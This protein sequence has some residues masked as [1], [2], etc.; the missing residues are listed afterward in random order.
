MSDV[1]IDKS[2]VNKEATRLSAESSSVN[3]EVS[4]SNAALSVCIAGLHSL[5]S[6]INDYIK[7]FDSGNKKIEQAISEINNQIQIKMNA[8][9]ALQS[10]VKSA[11]KS[12]VA[13][14]SADAAERNIKD[15][16][17]IQKSNDSIDLLAK[18]L[19]ELKEAKALAEALLQKRIGQL[20]AIK[21]LKG[22]VSSLQTMFDFDEDIHSISQISLTLNTLSSVL[23]SSLVRVNNVDLVSSSMLAGLVSSLMP[24]IKS[25]KVSDS[26][27]ADPNL[28]KTA[29]EIKQEQIV[30]RVM[31]LLGEKHPEILI[32]LAP[33]IAPGG[34][35]AQVD[36]KVLF[37]AF[38]VFTSED[39]KLSVDVLKMVA[40][41][42]VGDDVGT[43]DVKM[44]NLV[45]SSKPELANELIESVKSKGGDPT[46]HLASMVV[47]T[48]GKNKSL[49]D[50]VMKSHGV[51]GSKLSLISEAIRVNPEHAQ[52]MIVKQLNGEDVGL[53]DKVKMGRSMAWPW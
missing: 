15:S 53:G 42:S 24:Q 29:K 46:T 26:N 6:R 14:Q 32:G 3:D 4:K 40:G 41:K 9:S 52:R 22:D 7:E 2:A 34:S 38:K 39:E 44:F 51:E 30:Q 20:S 23:K 17:L 47:Y 35:I 13:S 16:I 21:S 49:F 45:I 8:M 11:Q 33:L 10:T 5:I 48:H 25:I 19:N 1:L 43:Q 27:S 28:S 37:N 50:D 31:G 12:I 18:E 36:T